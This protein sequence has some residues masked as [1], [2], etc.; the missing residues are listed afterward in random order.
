MFIELVDALRCPV[1]HEESWLVAAA[2]RM[3]A[4]H[5]VEGT[6]GC[7]VCS[8]EYPIRN[9]VVDFRRG[10]G[11]LP[12]ED[13]PHDPE[14]AMRLAA[15]LDLADAQ[16]FAV[17]LGTWGSHAAEL[18]GIVETP[19]ILIDPPANVTGAPG[20]SVLRCDGELP[21]AAG[22]ARA[23]A[24]DDGDS[25]RVASAVRATR[26]KGRVLAPVSVELP[27]GVRQLARD[28]S[29]WVGER[30]S[31]ASPLVTLHVRRSV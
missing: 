11:H 24:I 7:P 1:A 14:L 9:G 23:M 18:S 28:E 19:L 13:A 30:E 31:V 25:A 26:V 16:G 6:L 12:A 2:I 4:R 17:L 8:A 3:E 15:M 20:V 27:T 29:V 10:V 5:I 22:A 21:L